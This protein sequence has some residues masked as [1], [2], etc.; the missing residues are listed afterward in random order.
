[1]IAKLYFK[2]IESIMDL[3]L[4]SGRLVW[5]PLRPQRKKNGTECG[6]HTH[7]GNV[8]TDCWPG[9]EPSH[10]RALDQMRLWLC[11]H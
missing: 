4:R 7:V 11:L 9:P 8:L 1:M 3:S 2:N 5:Y 6:G 10:G